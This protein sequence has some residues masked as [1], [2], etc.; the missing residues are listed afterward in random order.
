MINPANGLCAGCFSAGI[1]TTMMML[2]MIMAGGGL[3]AV[4]A[5]MMTWVPPLVFA[6]VL[7]AVGP[8][9]AKPAFA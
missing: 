8:A 3:F 6:A 1:L 5:P 2:A 7:G 9:R 4:T